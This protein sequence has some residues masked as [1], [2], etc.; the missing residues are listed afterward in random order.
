M[1]SADVYFRALMFAV[2]SFVVA[3]LSERIADR[4]KAMRE[5][6]EKLLRKEKLAFLG[7]LAG[8]VGQPPIRIG[9]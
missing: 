1:V 5:S 3:F 9:K 8:G 2:I 6:E 4:E 7:E